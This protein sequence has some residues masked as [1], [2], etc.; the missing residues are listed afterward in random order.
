SLP[1]GD[2]EDCFAVR[3]DAGGSLYVELATDRLSYT[4]PPVASLFGSSGEELGRWSLRDEGGH[5]PLAGTSRLRPES[6][7][8]LRSMAADTYRAC[9]RRPHDPIASY[10]LALA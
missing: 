3:V 4:D 6:I 10:T 7:G 2:I 5:G 9:L 8:L 1:A